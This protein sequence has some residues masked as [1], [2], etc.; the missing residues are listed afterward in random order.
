MSRSDRALSH[1][2]TRVLKRRMLD[3]AQ[4]K[5]AEKATYNRQEN[6]HRP[7]YGSYWDRELYDRMFD[8][9]F[10]VDLNR[11]AQQHLS[12]KRVLILGAGLAEVRLVRSYTQEIHAL[13]ISE[14][15]VADVQRAFPDVHAFVADAE[16]FRSEPIYDVVYCRS[17]LHHLQPFE[18]IVDNLALCLRPGGILFVAAE[19]GLYNPFA[20]VARRF[21]PSQSHT[22]GERPFHF[23]AY[24]RTLERRF[25]PLFESH[26]FL[27]SMLLPFLAR[28]VVVLKPICKLTLEPTLRAE[29]WLRSLPG[30]RDLFWITCGVYRVR[31]GEARGGSAP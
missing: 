17:V 23:S 12:G 19:P 3:E 13:N 29:R 5:L 26:Y 7:A 1:L 21:M 16:Q 9:E 24:R 31:E 4:R 20:A 25:E 2:P 18:Q 6:L 8:V 10:D 27:V 28:K 15:A 30:A 11:L 22:P 14:K